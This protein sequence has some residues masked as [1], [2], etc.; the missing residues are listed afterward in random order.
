MPCMPADPFSGNSYI[1][2]I[3]A[4]ALLIEIIRE[5]IIYKGLKIFEEKKCF[6]DLI[7]KTKKKMDRVIQTFKRDIKKQSII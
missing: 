3:H 6:M 1:F 5:Y 7:E 2:L 4:L